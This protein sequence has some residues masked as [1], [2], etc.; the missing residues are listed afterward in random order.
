MVHTVVENCRVSRVIKLVHQSNTHINATKGLNVGKS[1]LDR[2]PHS[3]G[4]RATDRW[5]GKQSPRYLG[6]AAVSDLLC[7]LAGLHLHT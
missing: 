6:S 3:Q 4:V 7:T 2:H 1:V 5:R